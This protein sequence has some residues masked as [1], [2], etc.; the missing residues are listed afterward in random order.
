M[1]IIRHTHI[2]LFVSLIVLAIREIPRLFASCCQ[3][4]VTCCAMTC[5]AP[6]I[7]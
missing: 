1:T 4:H 5:H 6:S 2:A 3:S 7:G